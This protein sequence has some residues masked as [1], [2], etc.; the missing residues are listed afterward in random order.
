MQ[1]RCRRRMLLSLAAARSLLGVVEVWFRIVG[2]LEEPKNTTDL[3]ATTGR[4]VGVC[5]IPRSLRPTAA[6]LGSF[7]RVLAWK[8]A[9]RLFPRSSCRVL[10][11]MARG[12]WQGWRTDLTARCRH[13]FAE[14]VP[15]H[16]FHSAIR[17]VFVSVLYGATGRRVRATAVQSSNR[18]DAQTRSRW[19]LW[20]RVCGNSQRTGG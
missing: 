16:N 6:A 8:G 15:R 20:T 4:T 13:P 10:E 17:L 2:F 11:L 14:P 19:Q 12:S 5:G 1:L 7:L 9:G 3:Q 18:C